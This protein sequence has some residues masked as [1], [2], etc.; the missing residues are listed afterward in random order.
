MQINFETNK[1]QNQ[2]FGAIKP[3]K[4]AKNIIN[5]RAN[6]PKK[7]MIVE[8]IIHSMDSSKVEATVHSH[9]KGRDRLVAFVKDLEG[10]EIFMQESLLDRIFHSPAKFLNKVREAMLKI[11]K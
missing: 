8:D 2:A 5:Y 11:E 9:Y 4:Y 1:T 10:K 7:Y 3:D 6:S